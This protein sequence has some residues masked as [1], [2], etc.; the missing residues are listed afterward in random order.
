MGRR[1][2][3]SMK[4]LRA[5]GMKILAIIDVVPGA[6]IEKIRAELASELRR[7]LEALRRG[8]AAR[9]LC[10]GGARSS[11]LRPRGRQ[12][13]GRRRPSRRHAADKGGL[14]E[15][16]ADR[17]PAFHELVPA[18]RDEK[19]RA[20]G[21]IG[22][23]MTNAP[24]VAASPTMRYLRYLAMILGNAQTWFWLYSFRLIYVNPPKATAWDG[25]RSSRSRSSFSR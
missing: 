23:D 12:S 16:R 14:F 22:V 7:I 8:R 2:A 25:L 20:E 18:V 13:R 17:A 3:Y 6:P 19:L 5:D 15:I 1:W 11:R 24:D 4:W 9:G 21:G 10:D